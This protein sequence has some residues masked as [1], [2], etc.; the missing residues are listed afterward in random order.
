MIEIGGRL[1]DGTFRVKSEDGSVKEISVDELFAGQKVVLIG[2]PGAF[3]S[4]CHNSHGPQFVDNLDTLRARG[5]DRIV[6]L[7]VNDHHVMR[8]WAESL[9]PSGKL[10]FMPD[11]YGT[12][13]RALGMESDFSAAGLGLRCRRF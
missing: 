9:D 10:D 4:T 3:T 13:T 2:L 7:S 1:P 12:Y 5:V 6:I 11:P 8:A